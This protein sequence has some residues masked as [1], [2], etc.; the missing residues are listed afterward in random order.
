MIVV[1]VLM[2]AQ[3]FIF[4]LIEVLLEPHQHRVPVV[5]TLVLYRDAIVVLVKAIQV[6][7]LQ[8]AAPSD[9]II[10]HRPYK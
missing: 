3:H 10:I 8:T 4:V 9:P 7:L 5:V 2:V 6:V 1:V